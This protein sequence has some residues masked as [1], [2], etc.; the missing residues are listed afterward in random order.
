M[1]TKIIIP[2]ALNIDLNNFKKINDTY[3]HEEG[4]SVILDFTQ[5]IKNNI[6]N[7]IDSLFRFGGDECVVLHIDCNE[8]YAQKVAARLN[9]EISTIHP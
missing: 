8:E 9:N 1:Q 6:R 7:T 2:S 4:D 5:I 3:G